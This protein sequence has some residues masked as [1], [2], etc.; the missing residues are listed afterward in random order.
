MLIKY[1]TM[2]HPES[3][4]KTPAAGDSAW[5]IT[6]PLDGG[7]DYLEVSFGRKGYE[8]LRAMLG[9][10]AEDNLAELRQ[11][12]AERETLRA[13][14]LEIAKAVKT[15]LGRAEKVLSTTRSEHLNEDEGDHE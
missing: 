6:L 10:E 3:G 5:T 11:A 12:Q 2:D 13:A 4:G 8:A 15:A 9:Q 7:D 1:R 14:L